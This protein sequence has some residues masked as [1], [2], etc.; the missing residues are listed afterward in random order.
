MAVALAALDA[1]VHIEGRDGARAIPVAEFYRLPGSTPERDTVLAHGD[2][3][4]AIELP[5]PISR[6]GR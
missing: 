4:T 1:I 2:L 6:A 5:P 3:I